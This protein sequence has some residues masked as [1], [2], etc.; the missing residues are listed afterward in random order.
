MELRTNFYNYCYSCSSLITCKSNYKEA[1]K[2]I[3]SQ[4]T[5]GL[6]YLL[7]DGQPSWPHIPRPNFARSNFWSSAKFCIVFNFSWESWIDISARKIPVPLKVL[8]ESCKLWFSWSKIGVQKAPHLIS[9]QRRPSSLF[10]QRRN[11]WAS[12]GGRFLRRGTRWQR[13]GSGGEGRGRQEILQRLWM[14]MTENIAH[15]KNYSQKLSSILK[16]RFIT[17]KGL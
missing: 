5:R 1:S 13:R 14:K 11:F 3:C 12:Q 16:W 2:V 17:L 9:V 8:V 15:P 6:K 7:K 10:F 4:Q